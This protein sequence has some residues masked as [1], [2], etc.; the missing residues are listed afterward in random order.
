[1]KYTGIAT[2]MAALCLPVA[3]ASAEDMV[4]IEAFAV[5]D[6]SSAPRLSPDG[7]HV[8]SATHLGEGN[9]AIVVHRVA[10]MVQ[11]ALLRLPRY[12]VPVQTYWVSNKRLLVAKGRLIGAREKPVP[13]G[14]IIATDYDGSN[15]KYIYGYQQSTRTR[16]LGRGFGYIEGLPATPNGRFYM[17]RLS[18]DSRHSMLYDVDAIRATHRLVADID[19][20]D[21]G[22]V[23]DPNGVPR[24][25]G[26]SDEDDN[27]LLY[28]ANAQGEDWTAVPAAR[29]G[30]KFVPFAINA[31]GSKVFALHSVDNGPASLVES[32][33]DG[34]SRRTLASDDFGSVGD[35]EWNARWQ[36]FAATMMH[37]KPRMVYF[38]EASG[39]AQEHRMLRG[40]FP[41]HHVTY[42]NHSADGNVSLLHVSSDRDPGN[43]YLYD[44]KLAKAELLF[45]S[46]SGID[47][48]RMGERRYFRFKA[49]DGQELDGYLTIP[50][51]R[52]PAGLPMVLL[53]HGGPHVEG[54]A[55]A[56]DNDAQFLASRGYL[57]LQV[58]FRGTSGRGY[59]FQQA[60][61]RQWGT[62]IQDDLLDGVRWAIAQGHADPGR[63]CAYGIS[64]GAYSAMMAAARAPELI[65]CAAGLSGLYDLEVFT[66]KSDAASSKYGR[67]YFTR[68]IGDN[69]EMLRANSP[70][71]LAGKIKAPVFLAHGEIDERTPYSQAVDMKHALEAAG[72]APEWMSVPGEGHGFYS[73]ANNVAFYRRLEAFLARHLG[74]P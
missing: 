13:M 61:H 56:Y 15:Q 26:G 4:P 52:E 18:N 59:R 1:M 30:G 74:Q 46:R 38:D 10:G 45:S 2:L 36:P 64:F 72:N 65:K 43:W 53:P 44:R 17:R 24:F 31:E 12:E 62:R 55:W 73:D 7:L 29:T 47:P 34:T 8:A 63:M 32:G 21:L 6:S 23:L 70:T 68:A 49:S 41:T 9:H 50:A 3:A 16:G 60:G 57:V 39:D 67:S 19:V 25:A 40:L 51:G 14:E 11:T 71:T 58:N 35:V 66:R 5:A 37:G 42:A 69:D 22:F 20:P 28:E 27:Y 54:D 33:L 48:E